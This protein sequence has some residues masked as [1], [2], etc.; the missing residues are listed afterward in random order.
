MSPTP[1]PQTA[2]YC[3]SS[4]IYFLG[5]VGMINSLRLLGHSEPIF[6]LDCGLAP[7]QREL[8]EPHV[9]LVPGPR[10]V[11]PYVLKTIAPLRHPAEVMVLIDAD[12]VVTRPL[13]DLVAKAREGRVIAPRN[14]TDRF[15]PE[16]GELLGLGPV[17]RQ[18][19]VSSALIFL[20]PGVGEQVLG[21]MASLVDRVRLDLTFDQRND[22]SY[23][24][25]YMEQDVLNGILSSRVER[26]RT[27]ALAHRLVPNP[28]F[29]GLRRPEE[30]TLRCAYRDGTEPYALH[31]F[32]IKPWLEPTFHSPYA[33]LLR[34]LLIGADVA[35]RV[36][37]AELPLWMRTGPR[38]WASRTAVSAYDLGRWYLRER[39]PAWSRRASRALGQRRQAAESS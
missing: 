37:E 1:K 26:D 13:T 29:P 39:L 23:P 2:F 10:D 38:A 11:P 12:I 16:W 24:F 4:G 21:L 32:A 28:P 27:V 34:R 19:Y 20:G 9:T 33:R 36:S 35:V 30:A 8:L 3:M 5:V 14:D 25:F 15:V 17:R 31:H 7:R 18:P 6:L 22:P